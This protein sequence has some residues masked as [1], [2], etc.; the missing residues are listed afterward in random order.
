[1]L[2]NRSTPF[3]ITGFNPARASREINLQPAAKRRID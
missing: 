1:M 2:T 3:S